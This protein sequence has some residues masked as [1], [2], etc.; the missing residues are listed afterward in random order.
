MNRGDV[1]QD[2]HYHRPIESHKVVIND[3]VH[4]DTITTRH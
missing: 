4:L 2:L 3:S 1:G